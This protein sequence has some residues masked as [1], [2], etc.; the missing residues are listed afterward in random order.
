MSTP[1]LLVGVIAATALLAG[2]AHASVQVSQS[3][4]QWGNPTPQG[5]TIRA[6]DFVAGR[7]YAIGDDG[8]ALRTDDGGATWSGLATGTSQDLTRLQAVSADTVIL[9]GGNGCVVRRSDDGAKPSTKMSVLPEITC[10]EPVVAS[11]FVDPNL[12]YLFLRNGN[13]LRTTDKGQ[14]F[15]RVTAIPG[16]RESAGGGQAV[17]ADAIFTTPDA[18]IVFLAG[19]NVAFRTTDGGASWT[20]EPDVQAGNVQR[21]KVID[22]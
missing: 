18:G 1:R 6:I 7:G 10:P 2:P 22:G 14:T 20:P 15:S 4:W 16:T 21:M 5:N 13:V 3:G 17:P 11:Y 8:T 12:G 19:G 9:L